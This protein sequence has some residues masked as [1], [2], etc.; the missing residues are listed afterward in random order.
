M[1][2]NWCKVIF[3]VKG[4]SSTTHIIYL[5]SGDWRRLF[6]IDIIISL[7]FFF[8]PLFV[9]LSVKVIS[10]KTKFLKFV[11]HTQNAHKHNRDEKRN[12]FRHDTLIIYSL[13]HPMNEKA[14]LV[15]SGWFINYFFTTIKKPLKAFF[16]SCS[17]LRPFFSH[18]MKAWKS[19]YL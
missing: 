11:K 5:K 9:D 16:F 15:V 12:R 7:L 14:N 3:I 18:P 2:W 19:F 6:K 4:F 1:D 8:F 10:K 13:Q 17:T